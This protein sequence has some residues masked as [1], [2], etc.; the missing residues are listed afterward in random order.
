MQLNMTKTKEL[1]VEL[2][3]VMTP[4]TPVSIQGVSMDIV[5]EYKYLGV[6]IVHS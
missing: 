4:V 2:G 1:V 3:R 6:F 5:E